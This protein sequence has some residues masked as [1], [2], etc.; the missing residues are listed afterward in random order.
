MS[1]RPLYFGAEGSVF[2]LLDEPPEPSGLGVVL[3]GPFGFEAMTAYRPLRDWSRALAADG[4]LALRLD[5]PGTG[6]S[7]GGP[8]DADLFEQWQQAVA[9][10]VAVV[11][12]QPGIR[13]VAMIGVGL[14]GMLALAAQQRGTVI[15]D[16]VAWAAP[17]QGRRLLR[18]LQA[19]AAFENVPHQEAGVMVVGGY[20]IAAPTL[21][22]VRALDLTAWDPGALQGRRVLL[23]G[24]ADGPPDAR[25]HEALA[26]AG[27]DVTVADGQELGAMTADAAR[28]EAPLGVIASVGA[29]LAAEVAEPGLAA[30]A[31]TPVVQDS[32]T[33]DASGTTVREQ[34]LSLVLPDGG[35]LFAMRSTPEGA[36]ADDCLVLLN[37]GALNRTG[38]NRM[39]VEL[40]R[41]WAG[42]GVQAVRVDLAGIGE[43]D[44]DALALWDGLAFHTPEYVAQVAGVLDVLEREHGARRFVLIGLCSGA[45][46]GFHA[47]LQHDRIAA[48]VMINPRLL[49]LSPEIV[50]RRAARRA[51]RIFSLAA[52]CD[53]VRYWRQTPRI[54]ADAVTAVCRR[55]MVLLRRGDRQQSAAADAVLDQ[56]ASRGTRALFIFTGS[57]PLDEEFAAEGRWDRLARWPTVT[58]ERR[59]NAPDTHT[60]RPV[61]LQAWAH[62]L[63][64][65][66]IAAAFGD[67]S[68]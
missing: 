15:D 10:A 25:L 38:P 37:A 42:R 18:E 11:R 58:A 40:A 8:H 65:R 32:V 53:L 60:L 19:F 17:A 55:G 28:A 35:A 52:W 30:P 41:R 56:F 29:W 33:F 31:A 68:R 59:P 7:L 26:T 67:T 14:G 47:A 54:V 16:V 57:E 6:D 1:A 24:R 48:V 20:R 3:C 2:G 45:Y 46:L 66:E 36:P 4:H 12:A 39:W 9:D 21:D 50:N 44:G 62:E 23:L 64:D 5:L 34:P 27:A 61:A 63:A 49:V 43:S 13:R 51:R 22:A